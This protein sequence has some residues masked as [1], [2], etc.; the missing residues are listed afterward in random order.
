ME[1]HSYWSSITESHYSDH[2]IS[3][4][5]RKPQPFVL[6]LKSLGDLAGNDAGLTL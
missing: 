1:R 5:A 3:L 6:L 4:V 2:W